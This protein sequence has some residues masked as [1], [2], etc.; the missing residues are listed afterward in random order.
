MDASRD[1]SAVGRELAAA[2]GLVL[3]PEDALDLDGVSL[4]PVAVGW[5]TVDLDRATRELR[6]LGPFSDAPFDRL[7]GATARIGLTRPPVSG[8]TVPPVVLLE[9]STEGRLAAT[10][11]R[12]GEGWAVL[13]ATVL[14]PIGSHPGEA[15]LILERL[16][17]AGLTLRRGSGPFGAAVL[18]VDP[19]APSEGKAVGRGSRPVLVVV[20]DDGDGVPSGP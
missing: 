19:R 2:I 20:V 13:Y 14:H 4:R 10:L 9:P 5:A 11:A 6:D 3:L 8:A 15:G 12:R 7:L 1:P 16:A 17:A 18:V